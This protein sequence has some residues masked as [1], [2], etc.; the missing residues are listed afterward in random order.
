MS[1]LCLHG[2]TPG[3]PVSSHRPKDMQVRLIE[4]SNLSP[5]VCV[6]TRLVYGLTGF[7]H[8]AV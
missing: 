8:I 5:D 1:S 7:R 4:D 6:K 3:T 2:F